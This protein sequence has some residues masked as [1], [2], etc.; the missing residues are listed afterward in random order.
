MT[1]HDYL[2]NINPHPHPWWCWCRLWSCECEDRSSVVQHPSNLHKTWAS[3]L[4]RLDLD[5]FSICF[6]C[7]CFCLCL[8]ETCPHLLVRVI[9]RSSQKT[10]GMTALL[11]NHHRHGVFLGLHA[12]EATARLAAASST[13]HM[14][15][16]M[17]LFKIS[18]LL[19]LV[20][21]APRDSWRLYLTLFF[22]SLPGTLQGTGPTWRRPEP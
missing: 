11:T 12:V 7:L 8:T 3:Q 10:E 21:L 15:T 13:R 5:L 17:W 9:G 18:R 22:F 1:T 6:L 14:H 2:R 20:M 16:I 4:S 19:T